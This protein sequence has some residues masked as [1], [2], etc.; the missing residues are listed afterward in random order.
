MDGLVAAMG[1]QTGIISL[2]AR[3]E[4]H[5]GGRYGVFYFWCWCL[6]II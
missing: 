1:S 2:K 6:A 5:K 3:C 4:I